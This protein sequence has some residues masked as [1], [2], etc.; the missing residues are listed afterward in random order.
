MMNLGFQSEQFLVRK[1]VYADSGSREVDFLFTMS[2][3]AQIKK[4]LDTYLE[5]EV[6]KQKTARTLLVKK[7]SE[8]RDA[9]LAEL[10]KVED[11]LAAEA[12]SD[13][14]VTP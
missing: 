8:R 4:F 7:A 1:T 5:K 10:A 14:E 6:A 11:Q 2:E 9:L 12:I 13:S 3:A